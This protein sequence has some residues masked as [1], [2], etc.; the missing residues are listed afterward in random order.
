[1]CSAVDEHF[2]DCPRSKADEPTGRCIAT[3]HDLAELAL[4]NGGLEVTGLSSKRDRYWA[5][6]RR[7]GQ[8]GA[9]I[10]IVRRRGQFK[11]IP[12]HGPAPTASAPPRDAGLADGRCRNGRRDSR[13]ETQ[14]PSA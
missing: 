9:E 12:D 8:D 5:E 3:S 2:T 1:R 10:S 11:P 13:P 6:H 14:P 4:D 7:G